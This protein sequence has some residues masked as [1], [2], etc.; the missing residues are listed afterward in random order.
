M[1]T[2]IVPEP[3]LNEPGNSSH[4]S[5]GR[6]IALFALCI[7][8]I[9]GVIG[10]VLMTREASVKLA[11]NQAD[12]QTNSTVTTFASIGLP[13][14]TTNATTT[15]ARINQVTG[16]Y[17]NYYLGLVTDASTGEVL[18]ADGCY[19]DTGDFIVLI[20]NENAVNP[21]YAQ[22]VSFLQ[23]D[24]TDEYPYVATTKTLDSYYGTAESHVDL[25]RIK[26]IINGTEQP[27]PPDVCSDFA[28][29][30]HNDAEMAGIRCAYV[31]IDLSTGAHA[32]DAFQTTDE[33]LVYI[34]DTG[35]S[36]DPHSSRAVKTVNLQIGSEYTPVSLFPEVGWDSTYESIGIVNNIQVTWDGTWNN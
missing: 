7:V 28:E 21:T 33:G 27:S 6:T 19:D 24:T 31:Y 12:A 17:G 23:S 34:D 35:S 4:H 14:V 30:L 36:Q 29:R 16:K 13:P 10:L 18:G 11:A 9:A 1:K 32:I 25:A 8:L 15:P 2:N 22:L 20:N 3:P 26:N 5:S